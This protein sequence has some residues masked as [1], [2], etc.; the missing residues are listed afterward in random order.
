[1]IKIIEV[2][3]KND[4]FKMNNGGTLYS[5]GCT[6]QENDKEFYAKVVTFTTN[7]D[8]SAGKEYEPGKKETKKY[9]D[10]SGNKQSYL[11]YTIYAP[12]KE[13]S[14]K[15]GY[16]KHTY[17]LT[18]F[19]AV[20]DR[21]IKYANTRQGVDHNIVFERY[22][23]NALMYGVKIDEK[24]EQVKK[25]FN[26]TDVPEDEVPFDPPDGDSFFDVEKK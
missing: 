7:I 17:A 6:I 1:M 21:A 15:G 19:E 25:E 12:K 5:Y 26:G 14:G 8:I 23:N 20:M 22:I 4:P 13:W 10:Q 2:K 24:T 3:K 11:Q 18:E 9:T 16:Q